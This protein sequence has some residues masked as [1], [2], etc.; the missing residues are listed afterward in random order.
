MKSSLTLHSNLF[1]KYSAVLSLVL[2]IVLLPSVFL[3]Y[4][5]QVQSLLSQKNENAE[6]FTEYI[7]RTSAF[8]L[9][10]NSF[11][12]L[13]E[14][15]KVLQSELQ[16]KVEIA[17]FLVYDNRGNKINP[18]GIQ[19]EDIDLPKKY[20]LTKTSKCIHIFPDNTTRTYGHVEITYNLES[21]YT[22]TRN[23]I[24]FYV[25][26]VLILLVILIVSIGFLV[27]I[28]IINPLKMITTAADEIGQGFYLVAFSK[29]PNDEIG[30]LGKTI[31]LMG[32][33]IH[34]AFLKIENQNKEIQKVNENLEQIVEERTSELVHSEKMAALGK[35]VAGVAH[36]I[37]TP[38]GISI[39]ANSHFGNKLK[40]LNAKFE[41]KK[42]KQT[43]FT[44]F[45]ESS[46]ES[47]KLL[48]T[49]LIR[50]SE[51]IKSF[52]QVAVDQ[53]SEIKRIFNLKSYINEVL[54]SL[55]PKYKNKNI[56]FIINCP[57]DIEI[58]SY[59]GYFSQIISNFTI[60]S[61]IHGFEGEDSGEITF[62]I[63]RSDD[64]VIFI[65]RD[66]GKGVPREKTKV[67]FEPFYTT[68]RNKGGTGLGLHIVYNIITQKL[69][70]TISCDSDADR[71]ILFLISIPLHI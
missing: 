43:D 30:Y 68:K 26:S 40:D 42:M 7:A 62:D 44:A 47:Y 61:I 59:P 46:N 64:V 65:Y 33:R 35:L 15:T 24:R 48:E 14:L 37:N 8:Y 3:F 29:L 66:N 6:M 32:E 25:F 19:P 31:Q 9:E 17:S 55:K 56:N 21:V 69:K 2:I 22:S 20:Q 58:D 70:G 60:N 38:I 50:A 41:S 18:S 10:K 49:N 13:D 34:A 39:T 54:V 5:F 1:L 53:S 45:L 63:S 27:F 51:L 23:L 36:E 67:I 71:G 52:K 28:T 4:Q 12:T 11:Y 16:E 57:N